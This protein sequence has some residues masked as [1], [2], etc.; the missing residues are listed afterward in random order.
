MATNRSPD[1]EEGVRTV[2]ARHWGIEAREITLLA[3]RGGRRVVRIGRHDLPPLVLRGYA[4]GAGDQD[5]GLQAATLA[6]LGERG[7]P[8]PGLHR[9][10]SG[11]S[12]VAADAWRW[13]LIDF[14]SGDQAGFSPNDLAAIARALGRLHA[15][16]PD[17]DLPESP[18][19]PAI[20]GPLAAKQLSDL[21]GATDEHDR[22]AASFLA[23]LATAPWFTQA[24]RGPIHTDAFPGNAVVRADGQAQLIDWDDAGVGTTVVDLG[25]LFAT[26]VADLPPGATPPPERVAAIAGGYRDNR[27][28]KVV[29]LEMLATATAFVPAV[30]GAW[31]LAASLRG[32]VPDT[33]WQGWWHRHQAAEGIAA[34][35]RPLLRSR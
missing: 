2:L 21:S 20:A 30:Y 18:F 34:M 33:A 32:E 15:L 16:E 6:W 25:Y 4:Q 26:C 24:P 12:T 23:T 9:T 19:I 5:P 35:A 10:I 8:A 27:T 14:V 17:A 1:D 22:V 7:Y 3:E 13:L 31:H 11:E 28:P 29:E